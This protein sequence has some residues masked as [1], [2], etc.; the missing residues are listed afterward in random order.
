MNKKMAAM[1]SNIGFFAAVMLL[2]PVFC[3]NGCKKEYPEGESRTVVKNFSATLS[4]PSK[5]SLNDDF[6]V[7]WSKGD[8]IRYYSSDGGTVQEL[9]VDDDCHSA[10]IS[11]TVGAG[12]SYFIAAYGASSISGNTGNALTLDGAVMAEQSGTFKDA[13]LSVAKVYLEKGKDDYALNFSNVTSMIKFSLERTDVDYIKFFTSDATKIH[14]SGKI[15]IT[16]SDTTPSFSFGEGGGS[17]V[18]VKTSGAGTFYL[19]TLPCT[20]KGFTI[21][22]YSSSG[23]CLGGV[24]YTKQITLEKDKIANIGKLDSWIKELPAVDLSANGTA[25]C[26]IVSDTD[27]YKF[28]ADVKGSSTTALD[29]T[30]SKAEVLWESFGISVTPAVGDIVNSVGYK[31][32]YIYFTSGKNGNAVIAVKDNEDN[33]LWS[34][35]IWT[36]QGYE[37]SS[38]NQVYYNNAGTMMDRNLGATSVAKGDVGALGL[39]YQ[40]GRKDPFLSSSAIFSNSIA[41]STLTWPKFVASDSSNGTIAYTLAHPTTFITA[42][43][44]NSDWYYTGNTTTDS[45]RWHASKGLYDPCPVGYR[46]PDGG[47]NTIWPNA[48]GSSSS[49]EGGPWDAKKAGMDFGSDNGHSSSHQLGSSATIWYPA[50]GYRNSTHGMLLTT[51]SKGCYWSC[52]SAGDYT[53]LYFYY[54][55]DEKVYPYSHQARAIGRSIRCLKMK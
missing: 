8:I 38:T 14:G 54:G 9:S 36:C 26:Y 6:S 46:V 21:R 11:A 29:G 27:K 48:F 16:Y 45:S 49:Y 3:I 2:L 33:I 31:D 37:P 24:V 20:F 47:G 18:K 39:L 43:D 5:T 51:G 23:E 35:H 12:A 7:D 53:A 22:C 42:N 10:H 17:S 32:G 19:A 52:T 44:K 50:A 30:P 34:W 25:N 40:W 28:K 1:K 13:H 55:D 4:E 41:A 15:K